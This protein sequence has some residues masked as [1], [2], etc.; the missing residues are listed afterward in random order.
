[1]RGTDVFLSYYN[2]DRAAA[3]ELD[4][5]LRA[6]GLSTFLDRRQL[7]SGLPWPEALEQG[8]GECRAVAV[9]IGPHG[10]GVWQK[11]E[12]YFSLDRQ[13]REKNQGRDFPVIPVLL[14]DVRD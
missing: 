10:M 14:P 11:K 3:L 5:A 2:A 6:R 7:V 13:A 9:L 1:M 12:M 8:L 4:E